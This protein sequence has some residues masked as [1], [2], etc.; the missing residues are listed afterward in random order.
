[1]DKR[2]KF[3]KAFKAH[4]FHSDDKTLV[5]RKFELCTQV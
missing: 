1:V 5:H 3:F 4:F 2:L